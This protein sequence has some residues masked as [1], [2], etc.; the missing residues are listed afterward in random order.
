MTVY[1]TSGTLDFLKTIKAKYPAEKIMMMSSANGA[2]LFHETAGKTVFNEPRKYEVFESIGE[3]SGEGF[4]V[5]K[6][7]PVTP[8]GHP[9]F[10]HHLKNQSRK[11]E[12]TP[13]LIALRGLRP[14][15]SNTYI[16]MIVWTDE[17]SFEDWHVTNSF[18]E[19]D[20]NN[21][22]NDDLPNIFESAPYISSYTIED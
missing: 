21:P 17:K 22:E 11:L 19:G 20:K 8:E 5:M 9:I 18:L 14:L 4:V 7:I 12:G 1:I 6:N 2:L 15:A 3:M 10:E 16:I 13:G